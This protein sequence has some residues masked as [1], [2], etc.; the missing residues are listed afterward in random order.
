MNMIESMNVRLYKHLTYGEKL[1]ILGRRESG[2]S[3]ISIANQLNT[4]EFGVE[5]VL[6]LRER[7]EKVSE[8]RNLRNNM[9]L[10]DRLLVLNYIDKEKLRSK[11]ASEFKVHPRTISLMPKKRTWLIEQGR[12]GVP[13]DINQPLYATFPAIEN[14]VIEFIRFARAERLPVALRLIQ[15]RAR[16]GAEKRNILNFHA[17]RGWVEKFLRRSPVQP[18]FRLHGKLVRA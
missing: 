14:V 13:K 5:K 2:I 3:T 15:E 7:L 4:T 10:E 17:F 6:D 16:K 9:T 1:L 8:R 18:S 12:K 11:I